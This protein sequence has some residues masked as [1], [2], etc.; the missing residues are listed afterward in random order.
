MSLWEAAI[1]GVAG[2]VVLR[3]WQNHRVQAAASTQPPSPQG[4]CCCPSGGTAVE[5]PIHGRSPSPQAEVQDCE[6][7]E[8]SGT[9][10]A[11]LWG[12]VY[13]CPDCNGTGKQPPVEPQGDVAEKLAK[14]RRERVRGDTLPW[15]ELPECAKAPIR[16]HAAADLAAITPLLVEAVRAEEAAKLQFRV[17]ELEE[18]YDLAK[19]ALTEAQ[20][21]RD[22]ALAKGAE[23]ERER[24]ADRLQDDDLRKILWEVGDEWLPSPSLHVRAVTEILAALST[25]LKRDNRHDP[26]P[27][28]LEE[29]SE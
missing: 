10:P 13:D 6:R 17:E 7:C 26:A 1:I 25:A 20:R 29:G 14:I 21:E 27:S 2:G 15:D 5:C 3:A 23:E 8:G 24:L 11:N 9:R 16:D 12:A 18:S 19:Q 28:E 22:E 4:S